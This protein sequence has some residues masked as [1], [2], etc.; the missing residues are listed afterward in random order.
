MYDGNIAKINRSNK[1]VAKILFKE[2]EFPI[3]SSDIKIGFVTRDGMR[4]TTE[5]T[6][7]RKSI[8]KEIKNK[9]KQT[10]ES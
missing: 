6:E 10:K 8:K 2:Y 3:M 4:S 1:G 7:L 5:I 9:V